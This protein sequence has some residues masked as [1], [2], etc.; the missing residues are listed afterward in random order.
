MIATEKQRPNLFRER[1][2][3]KIDGKNAKRLRPHLKVM[4]A[5]GYFSRAK[6]AESVAK[7]LFKPLRADQIEAEIR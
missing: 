2:L 1:G 6:E 3:E 5:T 7:L 4:L